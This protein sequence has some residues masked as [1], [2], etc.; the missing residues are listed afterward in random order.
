MFIDWS[1]WNQILPLSLSV[2]RQPG[3]VD[4][5]QPIKLQHNTQ[6]SLILA[7]W[8]CSFLFSAPAV[9]DVFAILL[10]ILTLL[11]RPSQSVMSNQHFESWF[12]W[13]EGKHRTT[14][15]ANFPVA[16]FDLC[17]VQRQTLYITGN[18]SERI[19]KAGILTFHV[20]QIP[21]LLDMYFRNKY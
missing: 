7:E 3:D 17:H 20:P 11:L 8:V 21:L 4:W 15:H 5:W 9:S 16:T 13:K 2:A 19:T 6:T 12:S 14:E 18:R 1:N 10:Q